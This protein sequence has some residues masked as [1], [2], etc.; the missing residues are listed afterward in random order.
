VVSNTT[1]CSYLYIDW[2]GARLPL[3]KGRDVI[4]YRLSNTVESIDS[5]KP[6]MTSN[7]NIRKGEQA[8]KDIILNYCVREI[9]KE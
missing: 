4:E 6:L 8:F 3:F 1:S 5:E 7:Q 2:V 9:L